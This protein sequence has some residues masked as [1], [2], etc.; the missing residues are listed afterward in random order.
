M[1][2][3]IFSV[4]PDPKAVNQVYELAGVPA[5]EDAQKIGRAHV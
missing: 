1:N 3:K 2:V 4:A 5:F